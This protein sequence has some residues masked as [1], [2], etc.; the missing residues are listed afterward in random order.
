MLP[1]GISWRILFVAFLLTLSLHFPRANSTRP[2]VSSIWAEKQP[3]IDGRF[4]PEEWATPQIVFEVPPYPT[5]FLNT[6]VYFVNDNE[7]LYVMVDAVGD[8]TDDQLDEALL[9]FNFESNIMIAFRGLKGFECR[10]P[11]TDCLIPAGVDGRVGY[12]ISPN[13]A[14]THKIYEVSI[15][16]KYLSEP[17]QSVDFCSPKINVF[18]TSGHGGKG[19]DSSGSMGYDYTT[20]RDNVW[21]QGL[22]LSQ[23]DSWGTL[24]LAA[25][26]VAP[27][28]E[29]SI[30]T[31]L[32]ASLAATV[33]L[34]RRRRLGTTIARR[35][36]SYTSV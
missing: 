25:F 35:K 8:R 18:E 3:S 14:L 5:T 13:S 4:A 23:K 22:I 24:A 26:G 9:V 11:S 2:T 31:V 29:F 36:V 30:A 28:P 10:S 32:L 15:P 17:G 20:G 12:D 16:L 1:E 33:I 6:Y 19:T 27:I 7:K 21:P 34:L